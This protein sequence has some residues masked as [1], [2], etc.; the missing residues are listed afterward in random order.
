MTT[1][2]DN[3][4]SA[5]AAPLA[6]FVAFHPFT[7]SAHFESVV[8]GLLTLWSAPFQAFQIWADGV[9]SL[10]AVTS[11]EIS[12]DLDMLQLPAPALNPG[13]ELYA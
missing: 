3:G 6:G 12:P 8:P 4:L 7:P 5:V 9:S 13:Q 10:L 2:I 11:G 1:Y